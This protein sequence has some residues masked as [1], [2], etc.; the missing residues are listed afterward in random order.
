MR[1]DLPTTVCVNCGATIYLSSFNDEE[2]S[3]YILW[4]HFDSGNYR[5]A[6]GNNAAEAADDI[7]VDEFKQHARA[8][9]RKPMDLDD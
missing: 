9:Q 1:N 3:R 4:R 2:S 8:N 5:C 7:S 6:D